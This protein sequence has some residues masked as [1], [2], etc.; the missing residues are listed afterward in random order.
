LPILRAV[1]NFNVSLFLLMPKVY[2]KTNIPEIEPLMVG[3]GNESISNISVEPAVKFHPATTWNEGQDVQIAS[4]SLWKR[5]F[6]HSSASA[7]GRKICLPCNRKGS[8]FPSNIVQNQKYNILTF[9]PLILCEQFKSYLNM[10]FLALAVSQF[11]PAIQV[12]YMYAYWGP[13]CFMF[14]I[15]MCREGYDDLKRFIRDRELNELKYQ[16]LLPGGREE[17]KSSQLVVG[18]IINV[19]KNQRIPADIVLI[20]T[21][22]KTGTCFVRTDQFDG[23]TDWKLRIACPLTQKIENEMDFF[24]N[25]ITVYAAAPTK[26]IYTFHGLVEKKN[27]NENEQF[28]LNVDNV[29]WTDTVLA[30]GSITGVVVY[31]GKDTR[32]YLKTSS[33]SSKSGLLEHDVN[34]ITILSFLFMFFMAAAEL[35]LIFKA[36]FLSDTVVGFIRFL[37]LFSYVIPFS[38]RI[39]LDLAKI[40]YAYSVSEDKPS[41]GIL[42]RN[43]TVTEDLGRVSYVLCDKTG[44]LTQNCMRL[45]KLSFSTVCYQGNAFSELSEIIKSAY[46]AS[47]LPED[48][49]HRKHAKTVRDALEAIVICNNVTP[50]DTNTESDDSDDM[51]LRT[52]IPMIVE[53]DCYQA[54]SPDEIAL[55]SWARKMNVILNHRDVNQI[56]IVDPFTNERDYK[57][58]QIFPFTSERKRMSIIVQDKL[59]KEICLYSKGADVVMQRMVEQNDWLEEESANLSREGLRTLVVAK[60]VLSLQLYNEFAEEYKKAQLVLTNRN[61]AIEAVLATIERDMKLLCITGVEDLLQ[62]DVTVTLE[63]LINAG[64]KIWMLTGDKLE[65]AMCVA[66]LSGL[67]NRKHTVLHLPTTLKNEDTLLQLENLKNCPNGVLVISGE[68][69]KICLENCFKKFCEC[70][71][72]IS[73]VVCYR[74]SPAQK[75]EMVRMLKEA[76]KK[77]VVAA[78]GDGGNDIAMIMASDT[79]VGI[80]G[81]EGCHASM[82][83]DFSIKSFSELSPLLF[84]HGRYSYLRSSKL[85]QSIMHRGLIVAVMQFLYSYLYDTDSEPMFSGVLMLLYTTLYTMVPVFSLVLNRDTKESS[86]LLYPELYKEFK[87]VRLVS[88]KSFVKW[89]AT[90]GFQAIAIVFIMHRLECES[91]EVETVA[92]S[93]LIF[94][95]LLMVFFFIDMWNWLIF[96]FTVL[97]LITFLLTLFFVDELFN[98][99]FVYKFSFWWKVAAMIAGSFC[100]FYL[101]KIFMRKFYPPKSAK[102]QL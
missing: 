80:V 36:E 48:D 83:A 33:S 23:E 40:F 52:A 50:V 46:S 54:S 2:Y 30:A 64:I 26:D 19:Y 96:L 53:E 44:T 49:E 100:P 76:D 99:T 27:K 35:L 63:L 13:L 74:C 101:P 17:V 79:G 90:S 21:L 69:V 43:S 37:L 77:K 57:I 39:N 6:G 66:K 28:V 41:S 97:S 102:L 51:A 93:A 58:L 86:L 31:T 71:Q 14:I 18:D 59:T 5:I 98:T 45:K 47:S 16:V 95:E 91:S 22:E 42:V 55:V 94:N 7:M 24:R 9:I 25:D 34:I 67:V 72:N 32:T 12:G 60:R 11:I 89:V 81:K 70:C 85:I 92:F 29:L 20:R 88:W 78:V 8:I 56:Q 65:T 15:T 84:I 61:N 87:S 3:S 82:A 62:T 75:A 10:F 4:G 68:M 73:S 1:V 38:L